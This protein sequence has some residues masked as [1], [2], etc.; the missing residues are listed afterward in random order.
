MSQTSQPA[1]HYGKL[2]GV[3]P[4]FKKRIYLKE[5]YSIDGES[6]T[7]TITTSHSMSLKEAFVDSL[8]MVVCYEGEQG[9]IDAFLDWLKESKL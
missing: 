2:P 1:P 8:P 4:R 6:A 7:E 3:H 9:L 5:K